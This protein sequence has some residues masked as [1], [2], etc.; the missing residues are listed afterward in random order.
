VRSAAASPAVAGFRPAALAVAAVLALQGGA[1]A[2]SVPTGAVHGTAI[3]DRNGSNLLVTTTNGAG[4]SHSVINWQTFNVPGGSTTYF[5]QPNTAST[6][7]NRVTGG[8]PSSIYG[9]LGSNGKLVL[10]NPSGIAVGQGAVVD[11]AGFTASTLFMSEADAVAGRMVFSGGAGSL[12]IGD[13]TI[14]ARGGDVVLIGSRVQADSKAVVQADG[15]A[16]LAAGEKVEITGRGL[17]GIH[18][19]V[20]AG[21]EAVNLGTLKGDAVGIFAGTLKHSGL[22]QAKATSAAGGKVVLKAAGDNLVS[23]TV[24]ASGPDGKGGSVDVLGQ[25]V[26]LLAGANIDASGPNGGGQVRVGGDY[27]GKNPVVQNALR[28]YVDAQARIR[29][30]ATVKGDGG[31]VIVWADEL[32][33]MHGQ[34]SARGGAQGG[35][36]GFAEVSGKQV[37]EFTGRADL[38]APLGKTG[39]LLLDP[40][41][42]VID[43][44]M[45]TET[46]TGSV[47]S[48][49]PSVSRI[50][51]ATL[52]DQLQNYGSTIVVTNGTSDTQPGNITVA[53]GV[54]IQWSTDNVLGLQADGSIDLQGSIT[55]TGASAAVSMQALG[56]SVTQDAASVVQVAGLKV[57]AKGDVTMTGNNLVGTLSGDTTLNGGNGNFTFVNNQALRLGEVATPYGGTFN[58]INA[59]SGNVNVETKAGKL[60]V[61]APPPPS[62]MAPAPSG[63]I[64]A[65][66]TLVGKAGI[67]LQ[68]N[69][70]ATEAATLVAATGDIA[71]FTSSTVE[72]GALIMQAAN[73]FLDGQL[74]GRSVNLT[75]DTGAIRFSTISVKGRLFAADAASAA[76]G[77]VTL[78]ANGDISGGS[79]F[80]DG[81][82]FNIGET[83][84]VGGTGGVVSVT[85]DAGNVVVNQIIANGGNTTGGAPL[86]AGGA[87]G[88]IFIKAGGDIVL[89][90]YEGED[91]L[92]AN[93]GNSTIGAGG[94]GGEIHLSAGGTIAGGRP[95]YTVVPLLAYT[96]IT[97]TVRARGGSGGTDASGNG[98][99]GGNGGSIAISRTGANDLVVDQNLYLDVAGGQGGSYYDYATGMLGGA[100]G[101]GGDVRITSPQ[102]VVLV[103]PQIHAEGGQGGWNVDGTQAS[104]GDLG[105]FSAS[106]SSVDVERDMTLY[107]NWINDSLVRITGTSRVDG[108]GAFQNNKE[109]QLLDSAQ[110]LLNVSNG[111]RLASFGGNYANLVANTGTVEVDAASTLS[112]GDFVSNAGMVIVNGTLRIGDPAPVRTPALDLPLALALAPATF[113]NLGTLSGNGNIVV[114]DGAGTVDNF[115]TI[116]PGGGGAVG[117][118]T[119]TGNLVM[120]SGSTYA[121]DLVNPGSHD[122]LQVTGA[123]TAGGGF[124]VNYLDGAT[125]SVGDVFRM[126]Q[127][128]SPTAAGSTPGV[129]KPHLSGRL[130]GSEVQLVA[131]MAY[132]SEITA[133]QQANNQAVT[134]ADLFVQMAEQQQ[135]EDKK[136]TRI[137]KD[138]IVVT[139]TACTP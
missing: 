53:A 103:S 69:V 44:G 64:G 79:I 122:V 27:Q 46:S 34:I 30:D 129:D 5:Q 73:L 36:G 3:F 29:A 31:R 33:R 61:A 89:A 96:P 104:A 75:A 43:T 125:F 108:P 93:G 132:P 80:A 32:T 26:A 99:Q 59:G 136:D 60:T 8:D 11:T 56:G 39:T 128:G 65:N 25:R 120:E 118:L 48:G 13:A 58:G 131:A 76:G 18:L 106:G 109:L 9:K 105:T 15:A 63:V 100:G 22:I 66:V 74:T 10:V 70:A 57:N 102:R 23:G 24:I 4:T 123:T 101:Q 2:Q 42:I 116:A 35:D 82:T 92:A 98:H 95:A 110:L 67:E 91:Q 52:E 6:S 12:T 134:F 14:L 72:A 90:N 107:A 40:N 20:Q 84:D 37:L 7:I 94:A 97:A 112:T 114:S 50:S 38:R 81:G 1:H 17:E 133:V 62:T 111:G 135:L 121:A 117:T 86:S 88:K 47:F 115:G 77:S 54:N 51:E 139:D 113:S 49:G 28:T 41:D 55:A 71:Q 130:S 19:E 78:H 137:G 126:I 119:L 124:A 85:S 127:S 87:G 83:G 16:I 45:V 21:N 68:G 138:D